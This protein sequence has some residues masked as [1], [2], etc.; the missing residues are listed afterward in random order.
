MS[1]ILLFFLLFI[2]PLT[3]TLA[4]SPQQRTVFR[5]SVCSIYVKASRSAYNPPLSWQG[6]GFVCDKKRGIIC[7]NHHVVGRS[8][9]VAT[10]D[11]E[12]MDGQKLE[13]R[14]LY[15]DPWHDFA[16]LEIVT[17]TLIPEEVQALSRFAEPQLGE[18]IFIAGNNEGQ[19]FSFQEGR[20]SDLYAAWSFMPEP[21]FGCV[22]NATGG[23]SGSPVVNARLEVVGI[24]FAGFGDGRCLEIRGSCLKNALEA[25][26]KEEMP[27][28]RHVGVMVELVSLERHLK[29]FAFPRDIAKQ[30]LKDYPQA[31]FRLLEVKGCLRDS[32]AQTHFNPGDAIV[33]VNGHTV[34]PDLALFEK[35]LDEAPGNTVRIGFY[36][37]GK[38][39]E[40]EIPLYNLH[41]FFIKRLV[42]FG[43]ATFFE[44]DDAMRW[45]F[46]VKPRQVMACNILPGSAFSLLAHSEELQILLLEEKALEALIL[47]INRWEQQET[48][49]FTCRFLWPS[50]SGSDAVFFYNRFPRVFQIS[51]KPSQNSPPE[52]LQWSLK[53]GWESQPLRCRLERGEKKRG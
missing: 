4:L 30:Y 24:N 23:S 17:P 27:R 42:V 19:S 26:K 53:R 6:T 36:R 38:F 2:S 45:Q 1:R 11:V 22:I 28:R 39:L 44:A 16:F 48:F 7:T 49:P 46:G 9:V 12:F 31:T 41:D 34:G 29:L 15:A 21:S 3:V 8:G 40:K 50:H 18:P 47:R 37:D 52:F 32:P 10:Y 43:G 13:A 35:L 25:L 33:S 14:L 5:S 20:V 51:Y